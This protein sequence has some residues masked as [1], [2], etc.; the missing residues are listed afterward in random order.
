VVPD[1]SNADA[2]LPAD[3]TL[4][5]LPPL[6]D[7]APPPPDVLVD[8]P[9]VPRL[10]GRVT[11]GANPLPAGMSGWIL[12]YD[13]PLHTPAPGPPPHGAFPIANDG[14]FSIPLAEGD[15]YVYGV[16]DVD[17]EMGPSFRPGAGDLAG[18][19]AANPVHVGQSGATVEV[20]IPPAQGTVASMLAG[21]P[22]GSS[23]LDLYQVSVRVVNP[24][25]GA[26]VADA[27]VTLS[28][29]TRS[30]ALSY[31]PGKGMYRLA[32]T[33][34]SAWDG[35]YNFRV[36]HP[37]IYQ[38]PLLFTI[39]HHPMTA[40]PHLIQPTS[41]QSFTLG[42]AI[43]VSWTPAAGEERSG[44]ITCQQECGP[45]HDPLWMGPGPSPVTIPAAAFS[46]AG[47]YA[48]EVQGHR[49]EVQLPAGFSYPSSLDFARIRMVNP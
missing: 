28:D 35:A 4:L 18:V 8:R 9:A 19:P 47:D 45:G 11:L 48:V 23:R 42:A 41:G 5:D 30:F 6:P 17:G 49:T 21:G 27:T 44:V 37:T 46:V 34:P 15:Y 40:R 26:L 10:R 24:L 20:P 2:T 25:T 32:G 1:R 22:D 29:G 13:T 33:R 36:S 43:T 14:S 38:P 12:L 39:Q 31:E 7:A 16:L 3:G